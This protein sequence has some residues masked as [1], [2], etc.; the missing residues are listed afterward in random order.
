MPGR[1]DLGRAPQG[2]LELGNDEILEEFKVSLEAS[3]ASSETVKA[4]LSAVKDFLSFIGGKPL[5]EVTLKDVV[6]WRNERLRNGFPNRKMEGR[7]KWQVT[8]HYY[9]MFLKRFFEWLGLNIGVSSVKKPPARIN[10]LSDEEI[11]KLMNAARTPLDKLILRLLVDTGLRSRELLGLR[12]EDVDF[13]SRVIRVSSA[14][15]GKERYVTATGETFEMLRSWIALNGLKPGDR[16]FNLTYSGLYKKLKRLAARA[17]IP[18]E[19]IRPHVLRHT[20]ATR[21][22]RRGLSLP[23]LQRLLGHADIKTTQVYLHLSIEDLKK[24]Y[25]EKIGGGTGGLRRCVK[26]GREIP[27]DALYCPYCGSSQQ[28]AS[29][30]L[31]A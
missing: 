31:E 10:A 21:A 13:H 11:E 5:R 22:L 1:I 17:G 19:K 6:A 8:L 14:K 4:Y 29:P 16:L 30:A 20:F 27:A 2:I 26:C 3:G 23:S 12:V 25:Q 28:A 9:T 15:Y 18:P 7:E 24:E